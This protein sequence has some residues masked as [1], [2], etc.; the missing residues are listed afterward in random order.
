MLPTQPSANTVRLAYFKFCKAAPIFRMKSLKML[1]YLAWPGLGLGGQ[2]N[3]KIYSTLSQQLLTLII[4]PPNNAKH[5]F[6]LVSRSRRK[7]CR[8]SKSWDLG[9][10]TGP[11]LTTYAMRGILSTYALS[12]MTH[13]TT[14]SASQTSPTIPEQKCAWCFSFLICMQITWGAH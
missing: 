5:I 10:R 8:P 7:M 14:L 1:S 4:T 3:W 2:N 9:L 12:S 6:L 11:P 13:K